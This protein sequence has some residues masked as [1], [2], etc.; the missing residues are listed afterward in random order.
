MESNKIDY[1]TGIQIINQYVMK[2][3]DNLQ[4]NKKLYESY[5]DYINCF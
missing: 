5:K 1:N 2:I 4:N 3:I